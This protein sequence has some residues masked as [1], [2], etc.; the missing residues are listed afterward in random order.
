MGSKKNLGKEEV[1]EVIAF[2]KMEDAETLTLNK[3][4]GIIMEK[5]IIN[6]KN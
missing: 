3:W 4:K 2:P 5:W 6:E 1:E